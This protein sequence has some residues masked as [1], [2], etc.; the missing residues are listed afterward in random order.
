MG[1]PASRRSASER[2][3]SSAGHSGG[4]FHVSATGSCPCARAA[5]G[6]SKAHAP[7]SIVP[8][9]SLH[10][11]RLRPIPAPIVS[12]T[13]Y[14]L[15]RPILFPPPPHGL[16]GRA[17][18]L[19]TL[20]RAVDAT[21]P[22]GPA[23]IALVGA[24][25]SGKSMLACA[26]GHRT[27]RR[28]QGRLHWFRIGAW[29]FRTL[30]EMLALRFGTS[31]ERGRLVPELRAMLTEGGERLIV[32]DNHEDDPATARLLEE[33][34]GTPA[35]FVITARRCL[36]AGVLVFPVTSPLVT[37]GRAAFPR[38]AS[39]TR[40][41]RWNPLALDIADSIVRSGEATV[42]ELAASLD[43]AGVSRVRV[44]EH[45][46]DLPE[47]ALLV[48]W[49]WQRLRPPGRRIL[50]VLS[51]VAGDHVDVDSLARLARI[52]ARKMGASLAPLQAWHL[53]QEPMPGRFAVHA[54]VRHAVA[55]RT[56]A[57]PA[58]TFEHYVSLLERDP[59]R[60]DLEQTHLFAAMDLAQRSGD[61]R[62]ILRVDALLE[63][64]TAAGER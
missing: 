27:R 41:L 7:T 29:D 47:V 28:F 25:G 17:L 33:L 6:E 64:V 59:V 49:A 21:G 4:A 19:A 37:S 11:G 24:G 51:H 1:G 36:L 40:M 39:L 46:D 58:R 23:R 14:D 9:A 13:A 32:L 2:T 38:V 54:V 35:T 42:S 56:R 3:A 55:R 8:S 62:T 26:L 45:E 63:R 31:R 44:V 12:S 5:G 22:G 60:L 10:D 57:A 52:D 34:S 16:R 20:V 18:E 61:I 48:A 15:P 53:V 30:A 43:A 50:G